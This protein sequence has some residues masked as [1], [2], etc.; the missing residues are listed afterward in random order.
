MAIDVA[1]LPA[2]AEK[3]GVL[4]PSER[5]VLPLVVEGLGSR[6]IAQRLGITESIVY[7]TIA[8]LLRALEFTPPNWDADDIHARAGTRPASPA[9]IERFHKQFGPFASDDEG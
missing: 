3:L 6:E 9:E 8:D 2:E 1:R 5:A 7:L 4:T